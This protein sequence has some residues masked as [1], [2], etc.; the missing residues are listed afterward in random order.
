MLKAGND[1]WIAVIGNLGK[2]RKI[3]G[4]FSR[5]LSR[6]G[7]DLKVLGNFYKYVLQAVL[8]FGVETWVLTHR[9]ERDLDS[10]HHRVARCLT[11][12]QPRRRGDGSWAYPPL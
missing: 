12:S 8:L 5:I 2:A 9:I 6:E 11:G 4:R 7:A 10:L 1:D 3:W